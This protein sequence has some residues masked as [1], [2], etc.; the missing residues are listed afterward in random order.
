MNV[1]EVFNE[2]EKSLE[3]NINTNLKIIFEELLTLSEKIPKKEYENAIAVSPSPF[4]M[5]FDVENPKLNEIT[6]AFF[7]VPYGKLKTTSKL[8]ASIRKINDILNENFE[9]LVMMPCFDIYPDESKIY[10]SF[11]INETILDAFEQN[12]TIIDLKNS[13]DKFSKVIRKAIP[14]CEITY[15]KELD[16][17]MSELLFNDLIKDGYFIDVCIPININDKSTWENI[18]F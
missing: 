1:F 16:F 5:T 13:I 18:S 8:F 14:S 2:Y 15:T 17:S 6:Y 11:T 10:F 9:W 7:S 4:F 3:K 12:G